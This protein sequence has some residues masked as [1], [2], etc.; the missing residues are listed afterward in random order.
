MS[1][2]PAQVL[3]NPSLPSAERLTDFN[4]EKHGNFVDFGKMQCIYI[5]FMLFLLKNG[6]NSNKVGIYI[7]DRGWENAFY[8][9]RFL[10]GGPSAGR[11]EVRN[12]KP[13]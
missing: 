1:V 13:R 3:A 6:P 9:P 10:C 7:P 2:T 8:S 12:K 11:R 4:L 5:T